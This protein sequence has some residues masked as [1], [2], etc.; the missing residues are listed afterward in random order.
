MRTA[1]SRQE[2]VERHFICQIRDSEPGR[3][4]LSIDILTEIQTERRLVPDKH[5]QSAWLSVLHD[6]RTY[7]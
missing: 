3:N 4:L 7:E 2:V 1:E 6:N 5:A